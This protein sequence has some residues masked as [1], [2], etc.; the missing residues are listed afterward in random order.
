LWEH[1]V[2]AVVNALLTKD[3]NKLAVFIDGFDGHCLN[4]YNYFKELMPDIEFYS[5][6][7]MIDTFIYN[8]I[9]LSSNT[10][11]EYK[12]KQGYLSLLE[13]TISFTE[14]EYV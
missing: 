4:T 2:E 11:V 9:P 10:L 3:P 5:E 6:D 1:N 8:G 14:K 7:S 12:G 13:G